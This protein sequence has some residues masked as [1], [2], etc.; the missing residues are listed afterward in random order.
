MNRILKTLPKRM[1]GNEYFNAITITMDEYN[2]Y[3]RKEKTKSV[4]N[5]WSTYLYDVKGELEDGLEYFDHLLQ[6][7]VTRDR[8]LI[9]FRIPGATRGH[10]A[11]DKDHIV[12][13]IKFYEDTSFGASIDAVYDRGVVDAVKEFIGDKIVL[14]DKIS[15]ITSTI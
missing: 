10:I 6:K 8:I 5:I 12:T 9:P 3:M 7:N 14:V 11:L 4:D 15:E 13:E 2:L 1:D